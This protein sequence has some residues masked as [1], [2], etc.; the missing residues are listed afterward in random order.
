MIDSHDAEQIE[1]E[2]VIILKGTEPVNIMQSKENESKENESKENE[3]NK[4]KRNKKESN[5]KKKKSK[6]KTKD[7]EKESKKKK[8]KRKISEV[9]VPSEETIDDTAPD[10]KSYVYLITI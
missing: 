1:S 5:K 7:K 6:T 3:L 10:R 9:S 8:K 4:K 2:P